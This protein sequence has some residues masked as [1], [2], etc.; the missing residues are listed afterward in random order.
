VKRRE[1]ITL[2]GAAA[3]PIAAL[4]Q[5]PIGR[6]GRMPRVGVLMPGPVEHSAATL[7]PFYRGLQ[8]LGYIQGQNLA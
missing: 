1:F 5:Q 2:L 8:E 3:W 6:T 7:D 4:A